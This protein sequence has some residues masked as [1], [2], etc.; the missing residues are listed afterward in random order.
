MVIQKY[1]GASA[2]PCPPVN[3]P[4][5][6]RGKVTNRRNDDEKYMGISKIC[7]KPMKKIQKLFTYN[8]FDT[9]FQN[10]HTLFFVISSNGNFSSM[11]VTILKFENRKNMINHSK[12]CF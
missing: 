12:T 9:Y 1:W 6:L 8:L 2:P 10:P 11:L 3:P 7:I 4:M 5:L